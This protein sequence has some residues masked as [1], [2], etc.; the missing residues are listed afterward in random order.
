MRTARRS[1]RCRKVS[2][3]SAPASPRR[4]IDAAKKWPLAGPSGSTSWCRASVVVMEMTDHHHPV[5]SV[6][7][8]AVPAVMPVAMHA[9][10]L[11]HDGL[12]AGDRRR[13]NGD[14]GECGNDVT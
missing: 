5:M 3:L 8:V 2:V 4:G 14:G 10:V 13:R 12:G 9:A 11:H 1:W 6:M 7:P